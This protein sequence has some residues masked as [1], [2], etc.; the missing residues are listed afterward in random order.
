MVTKKRE[1]RVFCVEVLPSECILV[2]K[3]DENDTQ[4]A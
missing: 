3:S 2:Q 4:D 1:I